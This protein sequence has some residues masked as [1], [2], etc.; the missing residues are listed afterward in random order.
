VTTGK[1]FNGALF[2]TTRY[3]VTKNPPAPNYVPMQEGILKSG[4]K[5]PLVLTSAICGNE[6]SRSSIGPIVPERID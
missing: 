6:W 1:R 2:C 3:E 5:T 4:G